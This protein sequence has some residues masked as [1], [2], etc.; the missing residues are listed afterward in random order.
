[1]IIISLQDIANHSDIGF[2]ND[3]AIELEK[4]HKDSKDN[5][6]G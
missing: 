3:L 5:S 4:L 2:Y 1:M 6:N